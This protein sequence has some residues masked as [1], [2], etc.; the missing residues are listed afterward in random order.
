[1]NRERELRPLVPD[2]YQVKI[3]RQEKYVRLFLF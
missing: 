1:M 3:T 2:D